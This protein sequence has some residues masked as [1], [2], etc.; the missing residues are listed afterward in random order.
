MRQ[1]PG[2]RIVVFGLVAVAAVAPA[3]ASACPALKPEVTL[4]FTIA[5]PVIDNALA[6][7]KLQTLAAHTASSAA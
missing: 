3:R 6:Q 2:D 7:P 1:R 5:E 4:E